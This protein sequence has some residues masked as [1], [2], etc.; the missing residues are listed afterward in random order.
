MQGYVARKG[1]R[2]YAVIYEGADPITGRERRRWHPAGTDRADAERVAAE[3]ARRRHD[4][5]YE[6][7]SLTV[8][9]YLT[10]RDPIT[11]RDR[12]RW[13][14]ASD[15][16]AAR[17]L[18]DT[19]PS[20]R[21]PSTRGMTVS[22]YLCTRWL[23]TRQDR[24]RPT[25]AFRYEKMIDRYV[26]PRLGR[27]PLR[28]LTIAHLQ[29]LYAQLRRSGRHDGG[30]LAPKTVLNVHQILRTALGDAERAGLVPRNVARL[31]DPPCHG[32]AP[33]QRCWNE[34]ELRQFLHVAM[35]HRLGPAI[36]LT[37]MTGMRRGEVLGL[38]WT[39]IDLDAATLSIRRSVSCTGYQVHTTPTKTRT[40][41]RAIDLDPHTVTVLRGWRQHQ[42]GELGTVADDG[43]VFTRPDGQPVHPHAL[44][45]TVDRL[46][47]AA[48]VP[49]IRLHDL[50]HTHATLLLKH[51]IPLKVV[52]ER[53][54][55][56]TPAFTMAVYQHVLPGMQRDAA[57]TFASLIA[58]TEPDDVV[59]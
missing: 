22:R 4:D 7:S 24:L 49:A 33:E 46:Q 27:V 51:G 10:Q 1:D 37:A 14:R 13:H 18:A 53:L 57:N 20:A 17:A 15:E 3:L 48:G 2:Y 47:R 23:P 9:V 59:A 11:G 44:S 40:S 39:D 35:A 38:R 52:S 50:R 54:G 5:G 56:S 8:A 26:L 58:P 6:R 34:H 41:R 43:T 31:M 42:L 16:A 19:L 30:P 21:P 29:D 45:Q 36:W 12:R 28:S 25:T 32:V 55:H